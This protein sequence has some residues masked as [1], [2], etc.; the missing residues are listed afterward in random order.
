MLQLISMSAMRSALKGT[1]NQNF[2]DAKGTEFKSQTWGHKVA[3]VLISPFKA[4]WRLAKAFP[5]EMGGLI[6]GGIATGF[7]VP[8]TGFALAGS[9]IVGAA[10]TVGIVT[11][12]KYGY[13][14]LFSDEAKANRANKKAAKDA[15]K[16]VKA[17]VG[18]T[19]VEATTVEG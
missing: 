15:A 12:A 9:V 1:M 7:L 5:V 8:F 3:S 11:L 4:A 17:T 2:G 10:L 6:V 19:V 16:T 14:K 13:N 18:G